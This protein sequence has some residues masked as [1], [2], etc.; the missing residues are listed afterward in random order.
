MNFVKHLIMLATTMISFMFMKILVAAQS[1]LIQLM[2]LSRDKLPA[3]LLL[4]LLLLVL[5]ILQGDPFRD[6]IELLVQEAF[7]HGMA[8]ILL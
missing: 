7:V 1:L 2:T 5:L 6:S 4:L 3:G 8:L